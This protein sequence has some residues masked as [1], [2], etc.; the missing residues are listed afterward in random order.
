M[1]GFGTYNRFALVVSGGR[2]EFELGPL[3]CQGSDLPTDLHAHLGA[4]ANLAT[5]MPMISIPKPTPMKKMH[6][7][8]TWRERHQPPR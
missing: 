1:N 4:Y 8:P 2:A 6:K 3:P 5:V 7:P